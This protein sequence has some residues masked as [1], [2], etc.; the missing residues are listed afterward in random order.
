MIEMG[1][2]DAKWAKAPRPPGRAAL[3]GGAEGGAG[4]LRSPHGRVCRCVHRMDK[5]VGDLVAGLKQRGVFDNTLILFMSDNGGNAEAGP[6]GRTDGDPTQASRTGSA[7]KAGP[8]RKTRPSVSSSTTTT[9]AA[10]PR[11]SSRTGPQAST[12]RTRLRSS[13][14]PS[15]RHHGD[16]RR[17]R[18]RELSQGAQRQAHHADGGHRSSLLVSSS[19]KVSHR[20]SLSS[21]STKAM[22]PS[23]SAT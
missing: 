13:P 11:R 1:L 18:R 15:H 8:S 2:I 20:L 16:L 12:R 5:A 10:S 14:R 21:G 3:G 9:K 4:A 22:P 23:E 6:K 19:Q 17:C 7:A